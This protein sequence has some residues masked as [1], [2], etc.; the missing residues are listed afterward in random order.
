MNLNSTA[1]SCSSGTALQFEVVILAL[2]RS[3]DHE[4]HTWTVE[5]K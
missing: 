3:E 5:K 1:A 4:I 2:D